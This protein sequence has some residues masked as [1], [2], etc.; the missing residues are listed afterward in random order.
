[1]LITVR[2]I[3]GALFLGCALSQAANLEIAEPYAK[4]RA[5]YQQ[6]LLRLKHSAPITEQD[7]QKTHTL[8]R[9]YPLQGYFE[10]AQIKSR[11]STL[12]E[13]E[14]KNFLQKHAGSYIGFKMQSHWL[15]YLAR[16]KKWQ[17]YRKFYSDS[18]IKSQQCTSL[19]SDLALGEDKTEIYNQTTQL[20]LSHKSMPNSCNPLFN[21]WQQAGYLSTSL[22]WQR[23]QMAYAANNIKLANY[24]LNK[25]NDKDRKTAKRLLKPSHYKKK[26]FTELAEL[27]D[28][29]SL[30]SGTLKR[31]LRKLA[32]SDYQQVSE[33]VEYA[34]LPM[35]HDDL[36]EIKK[37]CAWYYAKHD[38]EKAQQWL[39]HI[40]VNVD[41][42]LQ[43]FELRYALQAKDWINY[44]R[45]YLQTLDKTQQKPEWMY[46]YAI[47][48]QESGRKALNPERHPDILLK[49][50]AQQRHFYGF[51]AAEQG[52]QPS[53]HF[54]NNI[55]HNIQLDE[56]IK[57]KLMPAFELYQLGE[58]RE[59][60]RNW[61][62]VTRSFNQQQ[63]S[64]AAALADQLKWYER[65]IQAHAKAKLWDVVDARFP[66]AF[67]DE[68]K[69]HSKLQGINP[70]WLF[71]M[72]R[73]ESAFSP[74]ARS[75]VGARG[76]LQ[77]MPKT[78]KRVAKSLDMKFNVNKLNDP[79]YNITLGSKYLK[80]L[81][82][83][84]DNNYILA[85][86]AYN[87]GPHRVNEWLGLR[88]LTEDWVH[89]VATIPY[90]ETRKYVQNILTYSIIYQTRLDKSKKTMLS[91]FTPKIFTAKTTSIN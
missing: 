67:A 66:L 85:T 82:G 8:L 74:H 29:N 44:K 78:A 77:L 35:E 32:S 43:E 16:N 83:K 76:L 64:Q 39:K 80:D 7:F 45:V 13:D 42:E 37:L 33:L 70:S 86:A 48:Q 84:Y 71:A 69:K 63:W 89:W 54:I 6:A 49:T 10:F 58:N 17:L 21:Q 50:L 2:F 4:E 53:S 61:Y 22:A 34:K 60:N 14:I 1:M 24:L 57:A 12:P 19:L 30:Q 72:A 27:T 75:H 68:F 31:L 73:Q 25:L 11:F 38:A 87:A 20:W 40:Q 59:A 28:K 52:S 47:A 9:H 5:V 65:S 90:E 23:F 91:D 15:A 18:G 3:I 88:P 46:W 55:L 26:W 51:L 56:S 62:F 41:N 36:L 79:S 81:L